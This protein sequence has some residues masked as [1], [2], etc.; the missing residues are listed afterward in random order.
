MFLDVFQIGRSRLQNLCKTF[1]VEGVS[2]EEK[3]GDDTRS[4][5]YA[6][7]KQSVK[8]FI[9]K[10]KPIQ[11]HYSRSRTIGNLSITAMWEQYNGDHEEELRVTYE[12]FRSIYVTD[13][14]I[15][16]ATPATDCC[17]TCLQPKEIMKNCTDRERVGDLKTELKVH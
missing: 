1:L 12:Y 7:R 4:G 2:P 14:N 13:Y 8:S 5:K 16:F 9:E 10:L 6:D 11:R 17:S 15:S 3:I